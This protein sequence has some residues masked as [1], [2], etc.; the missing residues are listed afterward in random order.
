[1]CF[2]SHAMEWFPPDY[3]SNYCLS[4][5]PH[6]LPLPL[7]LVAIQ[8]GQSLFNKRSKHMLNSPEK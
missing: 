7:Y 4:L 3:V 5:H 6:W 2:P 1:M 8:Q